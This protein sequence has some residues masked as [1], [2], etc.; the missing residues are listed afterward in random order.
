MATA[1]PARVFQNFINGDWVSS[2][3]GQSYLNRNPANTD[4]ILGEFP[5]SSQADVEAAVSAARASVEVLF[6]CE[7][8][9]DLFRLQPWRRGGR[10]RRGY[11]VYIVV[12]TRRRRQRPAGRVLPRGGRAKTQYQSR[13]RARFRRGV[14]RAVKTGCFHDK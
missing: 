5:L 6:F 9:N 11:A 4:E 1:A 2:Q 8:A 13:C 7:P 10:I 3:N 12:L 14:H